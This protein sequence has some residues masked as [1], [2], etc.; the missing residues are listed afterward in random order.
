MM[1][2]NLKDLSE[3]ELTVFANGLGGND[4]SPY[5]VI[6][7]KLDFAPLNPELLSLMPGACSP[8]HYVVCYNKKLPEKQ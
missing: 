2:V 8:K 7:A 4:L 3:E 5:V 1:K 6:L